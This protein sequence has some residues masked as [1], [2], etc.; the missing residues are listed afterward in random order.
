MQ[1]IKPMKRQRPIDFMAE[2]RAG[3]ISAKRKLRKTKGA[4]LNFLDGTQTSLHK[5]QVQGV[6]YG[7]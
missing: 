1:Y 7:K 3:K 4:I 5:I 6:V 2:I